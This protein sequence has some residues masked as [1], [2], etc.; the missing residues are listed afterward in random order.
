MNDPLRTVLN[1]VLCWHFSYLI[2][3]GT[4]PFCSSISAMSG[5]RPWSIRKTLGQERD[6]STWD[7]FVQKSVKKVVH[8]QPSFT[9]L[10]ETLEQGVK[11]VQT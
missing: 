9:F 5:G 3:K 7:L 8:T 4:F 10:I 2:M 1:F 6:L 11:Y